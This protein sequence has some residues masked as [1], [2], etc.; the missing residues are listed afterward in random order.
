MKKIIQSPILFSICFVLCIVLVHKIPVYAFFEYLGYPKI[1]SELIDKIIL[2]IIIIIISVIIIKKENLNLYAGLN[3]K[4]WKAPQLYLI[5]IIYLLIF[6]NGF[7]AFITIYSNENILTTLVG[8]FLLKSL[9]IGILEELVFRG[10]IQSII[11]RKF[12]SQKKN[13]LTGVVL[14]SLIFGIVHLIN[15]GNDGYTIQ[16]V[17]SQVFAATCLGSLFGAI[18]LRTKNVYPIMFVHFLISFFSLIGT[19]FPDNF[20]NKIVHT[21]TLNEI[22]FSLLFTVILFGSAFVVAYF[23]LKNHN[24]RQSDK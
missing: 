17:I 8:L 15:I 12:E 2:N 21:Q 24:Y 7:R 16:G 10:V 11:V 13:V 18:L 1:K 14:A 3:Y 5:L 9:T 6:T 20:S 22:I 19:L 23:L 4:T